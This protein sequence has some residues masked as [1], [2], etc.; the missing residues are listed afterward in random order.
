M[1]SFLADIRY[2]LRGLARSSGFALVAVA[3]LALGVGST[4]AI[5]SVVDAVLL[6]PLPYREPDRLVRLGSF[7]PAK[8]AN[9]I[10]VSYMDFRDWQARAR[11]FEGLGAGL[12]SPVVLGASEGAMRVDAAWI[13]TE[14]LPALGI[15]P[16]LGR[17]FRPEEDRE[18]GPSRVAILAESTWKTRFGKDP[19]AIGR[20]VSIDGIPYEIVGVVPD[21]A[22]FLDGAGLLLPLVNQAFPNRSGRALDA[23]GRLKPGVTVG[24]AAAEMEAI[25]Q[26]LAR[27]YP[28]ENAGFSVQV[29]P[30]REA[31]VGYRRSALLVFCGAV[32]LLLLI[33]CANT[34]NLLLARGASRRRELAV[35]A[36]LGASRARLARQLLAEAGALALVGGA[37]GLAVAE[38]LLAAIQKMASGSVP[39]IETAALDARSVL[40]ALAA[41]GATAVLFGLAPALLGSGHA[42]AA[43]LRLSGRSGGERSRTLDGLILVQTSLCIVLLVAAGL[44]GQSYVRLSSTDAGLR[45]EN[46]LAAAVSLPRGSYRDQARRTAFLLRL[47]DRIGALPGVR[48]VGLTGWLPARGSMTM[49]FSPEGHP[50]LSR[51]QSPQAELREISSGTFSALGIP[52]LAGRGISDGDRTESAPVVVIN[53]QLAERLWP[54][55]PAVGKHITLFLDNTP[56]RV[57]GVVGDVRRLDRG[58]ESPSQLYVP[59]SQDSLFIGIWTVVRAAGDPQALAG[60]VEK[61]VRDLDPA[62]AVS[63]V[64]TMRQILAGSVA[65]PRFRTVLVGFFAGA[66][67]LLAAVGLSGVVAYAVSRRRYEIGVRMAVGAT[68]AEVLRLFV[69][70]GMRLTAIGAGAGTVAAAG[71]A[72]LLGGLLFGVRPWDPATFAAAIL[73][74]LSVAALASYFPARRAAATDPLAALRA[75]S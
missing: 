42:M 5:F 3:T 49:S 69:G 28:E 26:A 62:V 4:V 53:R 9:G 35:R 21:D 6:K 40:F 74:L 63:N 30:L 2:G 48:A 47:A 46:V 22:L 50:K 72:R 10:G 38:F 67:L 11:S 36:A 25:G 61:T 23:V 14:V 34:A 31:L 58:G 13:S 64:K 70:S 18:G 45:P 1:G 68:P 71:A 52:L 59:L 16:V 57:V 8:N 12:F 54:D 73:V 43:G 19:A 20:K 55:E 51:A 15:E 60:A 24:G 75:D 33:A 65:E 39:R 41:S 44:L 37:G 7:H 27:E 56:R 17:Q 32:V 66:A 29:R